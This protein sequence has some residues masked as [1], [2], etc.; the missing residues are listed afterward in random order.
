MLVQFDRK[1]FKSVFTNLRKLYSVNRDLFKNPQDSELCTIQ[2]NY[3][4]SDNLFSDL[5]HKYG[6]DKGESANQIQPHKLSRNVHT[7]SDFYELIFLNSRQSVQNIF[8]CGI[9]SNSLR[10][11][12]SMGELGI[13][14]ASL[15]V[16][17]DYFPVAQ[18]VGADIDDTCLFTE[19]RIKTFCMD[20]TDSDSIDEF[21]KKFQGI[22]FDIIIDDGLHTF[23][24]GS[25]LFAH[26]F[27]HL[28]AG[29]TYLIEDVVRV[30]IPR[31]MEFFRNLKV[32][33]FFVH[34]TRNGFSLADNTVILIRRPSTEKMGEA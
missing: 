25:K 23:E 31:Y 33:F 32:D 34:L 4:R 6:T 30:D 13:P 11:P 12:S 7:Y 19:N 24:A 22:A 15:R 2:I 20:Q 21:W 18:I 14:G 26:S 5:C 8:E 28:K 10:Y 29:G 27:S 3:R 1:L 16:L 17:R 9:G